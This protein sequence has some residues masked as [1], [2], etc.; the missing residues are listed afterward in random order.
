VTKPSTSE[1][2][3]ARV[4]AFRGLNVGERHQLQEIAREKNFKPGERVL[5][6]GKTS[7]YLWLLLEGQCQVV[8]DTQHDGPVV[9]AELGPLQLFGEMSF[10][11]PAPHSANVIAKTAVKLLCIDRSDYD[12]L[13]RDNTPAAYK[14]AYNIVEGVAAKLRRMDDRLAEL[15]TEH[16]GEDTTHLEWR[17][18]RDRLFKG[19]N[20]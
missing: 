2:L 6:Q 18:F 7:Q 20:L 14:L 5:V 4:P 17:Q 9:L 12:D 1:E 15:S 13:I 19:W 3:L 10:F 11:S 16:N 8:R